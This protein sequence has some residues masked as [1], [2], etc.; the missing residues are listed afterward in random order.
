MKIFYIIMFLSIN[1]FVFCDSTQDVKVSTF[2]STEDIASVQ[3]GNII[4]QMYIKYNARGENTNM[5]I[6]IPS[7]KYAN[8]DF[9][10]Y[11]II[12]DEK[13]FFVYDLTKENKLKLYNT[14][15][16]FSKSKG[17]VY[18]SRSSGK[19]EPFILNCYRIESEKK[20]KQVDDIILNEI[21]PK[22][23]NY[24]FQQDNKFGKLLFKSELYNEGDNFIVL[25]T[26]IQPIANT[27]NA[28][29]FKTISYLIYDKN[30]K[31]YFIYSAN[32]I[33]IRNDLLTKTGVLRPTTF[34]NRLRSA[35]VHLVK[36]LG[37]DWSNKL[38]PWD[39]KKLKNG[40][41]K[42]Y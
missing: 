23:E 42:N 13:A 14:F 28:G 32:V 27:N 19:V 15:L 31:G 26:C 1:I 20:T 41:Y 24:F 6:D 8:E 3:K 39:E 11:E 22:V 10:V 37:I 40:E 30:S 12:N 33:R 29:E 4:S 17:T 36:M 21:L 7:T 18:Y 2:F 35:T 16:S 5:S 9:S 38:N 25:N 34:S